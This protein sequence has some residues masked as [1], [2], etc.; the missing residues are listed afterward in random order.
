MDLNSYCILR[1]IYC[2]LTN[3]S[4]IN[5][6][7]HM[8]SSSFYTNL[9]QKKNL[10]NCKVKLCALHCGIHYLAHVLGHQGFAR[11]PKNSMQ[12]NRHLQYTALTEKHKIL[13]INFNQLK[14]LLRF[15][16]LSHWWIVTHTNVVF[17][18]LVNGVSFVTF[19][20][21]ASDLKKM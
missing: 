18:L 21:S 2:I 5:S 3:R 14:Y 12:N 11:K 10:S 9:S 8:S 4:N 13:S 17:E 16:N 19:P 15:G 7:M 1:S 6:S 20:K